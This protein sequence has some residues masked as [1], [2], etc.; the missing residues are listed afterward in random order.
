ML[1][2]QLGLIFFLPSFPNFS[3]PEIF[4]LI[5]YKLCMFNTV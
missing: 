5:Q 1:G 3:N 4:S 2:N